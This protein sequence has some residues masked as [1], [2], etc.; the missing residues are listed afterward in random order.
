MLFDISCLSCRSLSYSTHYGW[1]HNQYF[2]NYF[3]RCFQMTCI[4]C[5]LFYICYQIWL[6][7]LSFLQIVKTIWSYV[8]IMFYYGK[9]IKTE[10]CENISKGFSHRYDIYIFHVINKEFHRYLDWFSHEWM[11]DIYWQVWQRNMRN[12]HLWLKGFKEFLIDQLSSFSLIM[13]SI[14]LLQYYNLSVV[15]ILQER[16]YLIFCW[17]WECPF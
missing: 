14:F 5:V 4:D 17:Y 8:T 3:F 11:W 2:N 16:N 13:K 10:L 9:N 7:L 15:I 12:H 1:G 6:D